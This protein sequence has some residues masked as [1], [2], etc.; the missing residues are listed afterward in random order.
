[1]LHRIGSP[2]RAACCALL[3]L[4]A[5]ALWAA[6]AGA[7]MSRA[8]E[9]GSGVSITK[10]PFGALPDGT[11]VDRYTLTNA[12]GMI[13]RVIT[14]GGII[15]E[16]TVPDRNGD[17]TNVTLGFADLAGYLSPEYVEQ[18]PYFGAIIGRYG[19]RIGGAKFALDGTT[20]TVDANNG[21][22]HLH[23]GFKGFDRFVWDAEIVPG[24]GLR[25]SRLSREGEGCEN[26]PVG[27][28]GYP[29]NLKVSVLF[30]L[31]N[32]NRLSFKYTAT[33]DKPTVVN[34]TNHSYWNL[35]GEGSGTIENHQLKLN[36]DAFLPV[37]ATLIP[38]GVID[39]VAGT[40]FDFRQFHAIGE[41]IRG[42]NQQLV[43]RPRL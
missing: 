13:V 21:P 41:R 23:G 32:D 36:A 31:D 19:N 4:L 6:P 9:H 1:M 10:E 38:T 33:T 27:C 11:A 14:Y 40:P 18:N 26:P 25:L 17:F 3:V 20:Y 12:R 7:K 34:L 43:Y 15:Q 8:A 39:P 28:T 24:V 29:G 16:L 30:T 35:A 22:N 37:D 5:V 42:N 2:L